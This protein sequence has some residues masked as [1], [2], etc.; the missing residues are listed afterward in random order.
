[1]SSESYLH[2][3]RPVYA[4][5]TTASS[6][7]PGPPLR[8]SAGHATIANM[9]GHTGTPGHTRK[10]ITAPFCIAFAIAI[11]AGSVLLAM[12]SHSGMSMV[13]PDVLA[14]TDVQSI[15]TADLFGNPCDAMMG[16][17][18]GMNVMG[19][20]MTAMTNHMCITPMR[21]PQSGDEDRAS[22]LLNQVRA[23]IEKYK[24]YKKAIADGYIQANPDV[25]QPQFHF[26]NDANS[27]YADTVFDPTRPTSLLYYHTAQKRF[28][29]EGVMFTAAPNATEDELNRRIPLS[30]VR[31]HKHTNFCA[32]PENKVKEYFGDHPKFGMFGSIHTRQACVAEGGTFLP[33]VFTWMIHVF[34]YESDL[35]DQ[36]SMN[37][38]IS[39]VH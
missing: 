18:K 34:P 9:L 37:D 2:R 11:L 25:D 6:Q 29:L 4:L 19:E 27:K 31:W 30:M 5:S 16:S 26:T 33:E 14:R 36:F 23:A 35:K 17:M 7:R 1:M 15:T 12:Q 38:D 8:V 20:S 24:D 28:A 10:T 3:L 21:P 32:A 13:R 22:A 39:H